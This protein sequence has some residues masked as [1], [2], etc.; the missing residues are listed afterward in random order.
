MTLFPDV[1]FPAINWP[2]PEETMPWRPITDA[3]GVSSIKTRALLSTLMSSLPVYCVVFYFTSRGN[4]WAISAGFTLLG[5]VWD[6]CLE[7]VMLKVTSNNICASFGL[8]NVPRCS[9]SHLS[10]P[11]AAQATLKMLVSM[12]ILLEG[13]EMARH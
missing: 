12:F 7:R 13:K 3:L 9:T 4:I 8:P 6:F 2:D 10:Q 5:S 11:S 1:Y